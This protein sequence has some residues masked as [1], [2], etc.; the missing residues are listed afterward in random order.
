MSR[1]FR[2]AGAGGGTH[3][4][5]HI[6]DLLAALDEV[7]KGDARPVRPYL[8]PVAELAWFLHPRFDLTQPFCCTI[9]IPE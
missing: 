1:L 4:R 9:Y 5:V 2:R 6:V 7:G 8:Q 3:D